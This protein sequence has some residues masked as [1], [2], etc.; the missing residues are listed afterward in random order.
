[1]MAVSR[2]A[3]IAVIARNRRN[4]KPEPSY[5]GYTRINADIS[6]FLQRLI[7]VHPRKSAV[8][9]VF[10]LRRFRAIPAITVILEGYGNHSAG[11]TREPTI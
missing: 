2:I 8:K 3:V 5:R 9:R 1:M 4:R 7:R 11:I 10:R 6:K